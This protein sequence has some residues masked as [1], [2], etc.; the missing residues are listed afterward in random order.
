MEP[1]G[2]RSPFREE[3]AFLGVQPPFDMQ[4]PV[5]DE[6][7]REAGVGVDRYYQPGRELWVPRSGPK[8]PHLPFY[9]PPPTPVAAIQLSVSLVNPHLH[10]L[11]PYGMTTQT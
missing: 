10:S 6:K 1:S 8:T 7:T 4:L 3:Q 11:Y 5:L 9:P 2:A